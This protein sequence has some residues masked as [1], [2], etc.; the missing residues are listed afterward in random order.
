MKALDAIKNV[1][2][3]ILEILGTVTLGIMT[4]LVVYQVITRYVFNAPSPF[5]EALSQYLFVWMIMFGSAYVYGS[6]EHLTIDL[7]KDKFSPKLNMIVEVIANICLFA[8]IL[9]V[10]VYGGWKYTASQ[11]NRIDPSLHISMA[12]LYTSVP[13]TGVITLYYAVYNCISS[14]RNY[15]QGK[16]ESGDPLGGTA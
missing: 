14:I 5:S 4:I 10:C 7:L 15:Q 13:F 9:L 12:I 11:V 6:R 3:K 2:N 8:F 16:R 1:L